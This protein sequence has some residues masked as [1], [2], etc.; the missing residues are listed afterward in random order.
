M[1]RQEPIDGICEA[2]RRLDHERPIGS[3]CRTHYLHPPAALGSGWDVKQSG[4]TK[5]SHRT[6]EAAIDRGKPIATRDRVDLV[7]HGRNGQIRSKDSYKNESPR[8]DTEH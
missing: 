6:Q 5:S 3:R 7:I 8:L 1:A 4:Q 2:S